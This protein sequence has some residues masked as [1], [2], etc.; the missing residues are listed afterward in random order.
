MPSGV[1][2]GG[3]AT[4][5]NFWFSAELTVFEFVKVSEKTTQAGETVRV[6][7]KQTISWLAKPDKGSIVVAKK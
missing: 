7:G 3:F 2:L 6:S 1:P 5:E 4:R